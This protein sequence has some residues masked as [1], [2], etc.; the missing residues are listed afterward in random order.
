[1]LKRLRSAAF[2]LSLGLSLALLP[3]LPGRA[4]EVTAAMRQADPRLQTR[5]TLC[6]PRILVGELLER[7][8][9]ESG[10]ALAADDESAAGS[11]AVT[12]SLQDVPLVDALDALWSLFSYKHMERDWRRTPPK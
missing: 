2:G 4:D 11:D 6:S 9:K 10:V 8:S 3:A 1:M 12:V 5:V 7:L